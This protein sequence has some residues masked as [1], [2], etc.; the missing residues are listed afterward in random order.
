MR[1]DFQDYYTFATLSNPLSLVSR[2]AY[3]RFVMT[4]AS[5]HPELSLVAC[6][7]AFPQSLANPLLTNATNYFCVP[8]RQL[9]LLTLFDC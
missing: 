8:L 7:V 3:G 9:K 6:P 5:Y 1:S 2:C 4:Q